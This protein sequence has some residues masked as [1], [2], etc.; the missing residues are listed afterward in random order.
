MI[1]TRRGLLAA[2]LALPAIAHAQGAARVVVIGGGFGGA[3]AARRLRQ[4]SPEVEVTL[5][6]RSATY[7]ACPFS[8]AVIA[9]LRDMAAQEFT[10][11][12]LAGDGVKVIAQ[13]ATHIDTTA[14]RV[15]LADGGMV[16]Y[17]RLILSP[18]IEIRFKD[19]A[20]YSDVAAGVMPH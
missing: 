11:G 17:D 9:G 15:I 12:A 5:I 2:A 6:E 4:I 14:R 13:A 3:S 10:Y 7:H 19:I 16:N 18:G 20:G 8:N 1:A